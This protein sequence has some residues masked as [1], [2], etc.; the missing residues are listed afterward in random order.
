MWINEIIRHF[1]DEIIDVISQHEW[2]NSLEKG[3]SPIKIRTSI[4]RL[5]F[6]SLLHL[7]HWSFVSMWAWLCWIHLWRFMSNNKGWALSIKNTSY[8]KWIIHDPGFISSFCVSLMMES[9][10]DAGNR[11]PRG[12]LDLQPKCILS[13]RISTPLARYLLL[14]F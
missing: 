1:H 6:N 14:L 11:G 9:Y 2:D 5:V 7:S 13:V 10:L 12:S 4:C 3:S 8:C